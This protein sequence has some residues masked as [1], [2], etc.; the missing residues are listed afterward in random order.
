MSHLLHS[1]YSSFSNLFFNVLFFIGFHLSGVVHEKIGICN[2]QRTCVFQCSMTFDRKC[3]T[4]TD[5]TCTNKSLLWC[6][7]IVAVALYR[8]RNAKS[9]PVKPPISDSVLELSKTQIQKLLL[10]LVS[11][12]RN[13]ILPAV[14]QLL[15]EVRLPD[16]EISLLPGVPDPTAGGCSGEENLWHIDDDYIKKQ[17]RSD[18]AEGTSGK[19][20]ISLLNKV[21]IL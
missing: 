10:T 7:H 8:I 6:S 19:N 17:V 3:I 14:Q 16:S 21:C 13:E 15:D 18:L 20:I 1:L 2:R 12:K 9:V 11:K 5:C 4:S